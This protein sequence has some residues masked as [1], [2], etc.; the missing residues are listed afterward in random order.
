MTLSCGL[1]IVTTNVS[2]AHEI[3]N[4]GC[5]GYVVEDR[6]PEKFADAMRK[7]LILEDVKEFSIKESEKYAL[8][9]LAR[10]LGNIF[11]PLKGN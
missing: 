2:S 6:D 4:E 11:T 5:N 1:P 3:I 9:Y 8:K 10:D 7:A